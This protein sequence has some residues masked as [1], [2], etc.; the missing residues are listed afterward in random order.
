MEPFVER[1]VINKTF[2]TNVFATEGHVLGERKCHP[3]LP[4][5]KILPSQC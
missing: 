2:G 4:K 5:L 3:A 1:D